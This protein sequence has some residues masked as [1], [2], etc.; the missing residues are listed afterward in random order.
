MQLRESETAVN[1]MVSCSEVVCSDSGDVAE[2]P[3]SWEFRLLLA[4]K[5]DDPGWEVAPEELVFR[6]HN[7][8]PLR[9]LVEQV[10]TAFTYCR[11]SRLL[12]ATHPSMVGA[13]VFYPSFTDSTPCQYVGEDSPLRATVTQVLVDGLLGSLDPEL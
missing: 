7:P 5:G 2:R 1:A 6:L 9:R 12:S 8:G 11:S 4:P 13:L 3:D 10:D